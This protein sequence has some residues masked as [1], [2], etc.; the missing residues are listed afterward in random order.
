MLWPDK[1]LDYVRVENDAAG[2]HF[3]AL[4]GEELVAV[5]SLFVTG[6]EARFRKFATRPDC[7][8]RGIGSA[9]LRHTF[10]E[11]LMRGATHIWCDARQE[12]AGF[13]YRFGMRQ[14]GEP[15]FKGAVPY[16]RMRAT[17]DFSAVGC[18]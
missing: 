5:I 14:T 9:L 16:V 15:F 11:A 3:G 7:Q 12:A 13:Y 18:V 8:H 1:P 10:A 6:H 2:F 4:R 17:L